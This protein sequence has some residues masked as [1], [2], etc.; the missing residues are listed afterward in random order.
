MV[1]YR[2]GDKVNVAFDVKSRRP[3]WLGLCEILGF[4]E[5]GLVRIRLLKRRYFKVSGHE[6]QNYER[7][8][9]PDR[10]MKTPDQ[11]KASD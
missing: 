9:K 6:I 7:Y 2:I 8:V 3:T 10:I 1:Q 11:A 4:T 5:S